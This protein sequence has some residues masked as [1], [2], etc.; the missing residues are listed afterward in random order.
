VQA[1]VVVVGGGIAGS[2][3]AATLAPAGLSVLVLERQTQYRDKVRGEYMHPWGAAEA[4]R[5]GLVDTL[6]TAGGGF[7]DRF[8]PYEEG[9]DPADAE[10][11]SLP[12]SMIPGV[13]GAINVGHPQA[14]EALNALAEARGATVVRGVG[15]VSVTDGA[16]PRVQYEL[17]GLLHDVDCRFIVGADGRQSTVRRAL[18]IDMRYEESKYLLGGMLVR[19]EG[20]SDASVSGTEGDVHF[21]IFPR[22]NGFARLYVACAPGPHT[23][24][25]DK[26]RH[27]LDS[28]RL[29]CIPYGDALADAEQAGPVAYV[30]GSDSWIDRPVGSNVVLVGDAAGWTD[31]IIG[32]GLSM[33]MRD[34]RMVAEVLLADDWSVDAFEPYAVERAERSRR[35]RI[36]GRVI[37]ELRCTFG[38][39]GRARREAFGVEVQSNPLTVA[40]AACC[41]GGPE[42]APPEAFTD[43]NVERILSLR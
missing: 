28:F 43:E 30:P 12:L 40:L 10:A 42:N 37:T 4:Q 21:L 2:A 18:G 16:S 9:V 19:G 11:R 41:I 15:D 33:A 32:E 24:G 1:D 26:A 29:E 13:A 38:P 5:L 3:L 8:V 14:S 25:S 6:L 34:A 20:W 7:C 39:E 35:L 36:S 17:D 22:P 27:F 31:P 23:S